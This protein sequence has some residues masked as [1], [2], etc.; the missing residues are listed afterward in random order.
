[1]QK[2]V[3]ALGLAA[4]MVIAGLFSWSAEATTSS[5]FAKRQ[6][7]SSTIHRLK[8]LLALAMASIARLG[9]Y[10]LVVRGGAGALVAKAAPLE[11]LGTRLQ[12]ADA[13]EMRRAPATAS[14][15]FC[16]SSPTRSG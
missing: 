13:A 11:P 12:V 15:P 9:T 10:G 5:G 7:R 2:L 6:L 3:V 16:L 4:A 8:E 1:M 14:R